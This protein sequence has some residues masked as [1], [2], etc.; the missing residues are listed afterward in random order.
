MRDPSG[1][2]VPH[3]P[4]AG[5]RLL[6]SIRVFYPRWL[7]PRVPV[8]H[9]WWKARPGA[10]IVRASGTVNSKLAELSVR[11]LAWK[12]DAVPESLRMRGKVKETTG[13]EVGEEESNWLEICIAAQCRVDGSFE[14]PATLA[15]QR[16]NVYAGV[17]RGRYNAATANKFDR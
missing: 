3:T 10:P 7:I 1:D 17:T 16:E 8:V 2:L 5:A 15:S 9:L 11:K 14:T 6:A 12:C 4:A 13:K